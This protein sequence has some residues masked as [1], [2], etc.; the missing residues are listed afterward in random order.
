MSGY[1]QSGGQTWQCRVCGTRSEAGTDFCTQ[2]GERR[3]TGEATGPAMGGAEPRVPMVTSSSLPPG[4]PRAEPTGMWDE[5][6]RAVPPVPGPTAAAG[7][8]GPSGYGPSES[9]GKDNG[10]IWWAV[11]GLGAVAVILAVVLVL[12][13]VNR[14]GNSHKLATVNSNTLPA[15]ESTTVP[16]SS[17]TSPTTDA[18]PSTIPATVPRTVAPQTAPPTTAATDDAESAAASSLSSIADSDQ[19]AVESLVNSWVPQIDSKKVGLVADGK[20][21]D[22]EA[23]LQNYED[24]TDEYDNVLLIRS[25]DFEDFEPGYW[26]VVVGQPYDDADGALGWCTNEHIDRDHCYAKLIS[27]DPNADPDTKLQPQ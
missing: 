26:V 11:G 9:G 23:I 24:Y 20:T 18:V 6:T 4:S 2:C 8:S 15:R 17:E 5:P 7:P 27:H 1:G 22:N 14:G 19:D 3:G 25:S 16:E 10:K 21:W 12:V 13:L